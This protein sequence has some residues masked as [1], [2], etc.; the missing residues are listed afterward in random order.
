MR[1]LNYCLQLLSRHP[2]GLP[3]RGN[4]TTKAPPLLW[5]HT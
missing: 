3:I 5:D 4:D 1:I 2:P